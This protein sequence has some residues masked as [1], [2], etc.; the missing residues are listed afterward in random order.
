MTTL[1]DIAKRSLRILQVISWTD[2]SIETEM[3]EIIIRALEEEISSSSISD[4]FHFKETK[5]TFLLTNGKTEY[6]IGPGLDFDTQTPYKISAAFVKSQNFQYELKLNL[7]EEEFINNSFPSFYEP[8]ESIYNMYYSLYDNSKGI[9][10]L[11]SCIV[12][13]SNASLE[14][15]SIKNII[16]LPLTSLDVEINLPLYYDKMLSY[17][18]AHTLSPEFATKFPPDAL[19]QKNESIS[20]VRSNSI[21]SK[22][23]PSKGNCEL[24]YPMYRGY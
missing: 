9:I 15:F 5:E 20:N 16:P 17:C 4:L 8:Y 6:E 7:S 11:N 12:S 21:V 19:I 18:L 1:R 22:Q 3:E 13:F 10:Y 2:S 24:F 14:I 23:R